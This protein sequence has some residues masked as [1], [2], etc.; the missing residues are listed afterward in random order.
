M[1]HAEFEA[2]IKQATQTKGLAP[3][4]EFFTQSEHKEISD[5]A[6]SLKGQFS[7]AELDG[8]LRIYHVTEQTDDEGNSEQFLE[9]VMNEGDDVIQFVAW[10]FESQFEY[11]AK[12]IYQ[13][14]GK[15]YRQPKRS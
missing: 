11:S 13:I 5:A 2:I 4:L 15:T 10:F 8:Q 7:A 9:H 12:E 1:Q 6:Q 14:A 3:A